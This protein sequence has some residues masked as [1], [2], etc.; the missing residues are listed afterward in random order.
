[1]DCIGCNLCV[2]MCLVKD[3]VFVMKLFEEVVVK[4]NLNWLFV[5]NVKLKKNFGKKNIVFGS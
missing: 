4:E 1:M 3:K 2:E 5:I